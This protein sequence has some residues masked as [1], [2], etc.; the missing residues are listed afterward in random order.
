MTSLILR[1]ATRILIPL[2]S[3][4]SVFLLVR[5]HHAP[6]GGFSGGLVA[7]TAS[8][9]YILAHEGETGHHLF[10]V[11]FR[12]VIGGG[13]FLALGSGA[14]AL[15]KGEEWLTGQWITLSLW[16]LGTFDLGT[17]LLFDVGVYLVVV[18]VTG[19]I[20]LSLAEE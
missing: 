19:T 12:I 17:P 4:F 5:G 1:V 3:L 18:G 14:I 20:L 2:L 9:L 15:F 7:A 6:G 8:A 10:P 11:S 16:S 13:L